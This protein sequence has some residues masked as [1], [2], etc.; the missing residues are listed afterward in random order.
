MVLFQ[1]VYLLKANCIN[2]YDTAS[3]MIP[4]VSKPSLLFCCR[5]KEMGAN[6]AQMQSGR[7]AQESAR[8]Q[9][10]C[11]S[12]VYISMGQVKNK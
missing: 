5:Q 9:I 3:F 1:N 8:W 7:K 12:T 11:V 4:G 6:A 2:C 10:G